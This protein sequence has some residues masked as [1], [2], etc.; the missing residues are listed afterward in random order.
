MSY[1]EATGM[2]G[3][4]RGSTAMAGVLKAGGLREEGRYDPSWTS[5]GLPM[6]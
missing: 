5:L 1:P 6:Q 3:S 4:F 2:F